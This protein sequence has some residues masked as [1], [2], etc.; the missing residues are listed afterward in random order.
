MAATIAPMGG[1]T[2]RSSTR[3]QSGGSEG[4][5]EPPVV[6]WIAFMEAHAA[7][8]DALEERLQAEMGLPLSWHEVMVRLSAAPE[9]SMRMQDL[10]RS[11]LLSK[12]GVTRLVDRMQA[13]GLVDRRACS[14]DRRVTYA[15][16]TEEGRDVLARAFPVFARGFAESFACFLSDDDART[17][18]ATMEKILAG[19]GKADG[20][21][22]PSTYLR[23]APVPVG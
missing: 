17:L 6:A 16:I 7:V 11:V 2:A 21:P 15:A 14:A 22:C 23:G 19:N 20:R 5:D 13:A 3:S 12:S 18:Q 10:A 9:G 8:T 1:R 4:I